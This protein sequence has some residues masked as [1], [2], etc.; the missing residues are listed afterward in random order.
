M[1]VSWQSSPATVTRRERPKLLFDSSGQP[2][3][4]FN[5]VCLA[6]SSKNCFT[7]AQEI[8]SL[9]A[10][11]HTAVLQLKSDDG[12]DEPTWWTRLLLDPRTVNHS[13]TTAVLRPGKPLKH[14]RNPLLSD[15]NRG[16]ETGAM[17]FG[18]ID[19]LYDERQLFKLWYNTPSCPG[20]DGAYVDL[21]YRSS[22]DGLEWPLPNPVSYTHLT[23][24]TKA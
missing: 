5:G 15:A 18:D 6:G 19:V 8:E 11:G 22:A 16:E 13:A 9:N 3:W 17:I 1:D 24:P 7:F 20:V 10:D 23:L 14:P 4:L 21:V 2:R 12:M